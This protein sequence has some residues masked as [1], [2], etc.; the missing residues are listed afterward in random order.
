MKIKDLIQVFENC[1]D[2]GYKILNW[3][4]S[5]EITEVDPEN[6]WKCFKQGPEIFINITIAK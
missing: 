6:G 1:R 2:H 5:R 4:I 3:S